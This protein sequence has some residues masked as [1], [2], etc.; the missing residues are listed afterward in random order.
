[1]ST[2]KNITKLPSMKKEIISFAKNGKKV[3]KIVEDKDLYLVTMNSGASVALHGKDLN[4]YKVTEDKTKELT[5]SDQDLDEDDDLIEEE[6]D[7]T[8]TE[9]INNSPANLGDK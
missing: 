4:Y 1:M 9:N 7:A 2:V 8:I 5:K 3:V 6:K